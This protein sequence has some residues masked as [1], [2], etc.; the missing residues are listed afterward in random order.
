MCANTWTTRV[1]L[2]TV[3]KLHITRNS[4]F[5]W[6]SA[7]IWMRT[8]FEKW[9]IISTDKTDREKDRQRER[10][11]ERKKERENDRKRER[12]SERRA[13]SLFRIKRN[14]T[15][16]WYASFFYRDIDCCYSHWVCVCICVWRTHRQ[17]S[18]PKIIDY[19]CVWYHLVEHSF[20]SA[21]DFVLLW[22]F[23][24][25]FG[26]FFLFVFVMSQFPTV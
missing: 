16:Y 9:P 21:R 12:E 14:H 10:Q 7:E 15:S 25:Y 5:I 19:L 23:S 18:I 20:L 6:Y 8:A 24:V 26:F 17:R 4:L 13:Q 22:T 1:L 2:H 11:K 3:N